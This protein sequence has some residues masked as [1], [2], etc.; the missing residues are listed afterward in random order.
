[1]SFNL[2]MFRILNNRMKYL[3]RLSEEGTLKQLHYEDLETRIIYGASLNP[4]KHMIAVSV[5]NT[6][7]VYTFSL[8]DEKISY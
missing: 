5:E 2:K 6:L 3:F 7:V 1:M 4:R 8:K